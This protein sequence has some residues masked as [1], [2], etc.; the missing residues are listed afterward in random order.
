MLL[1]VACGRGNFQECGS[2]GDAAT[3]PQAG[4][5]V[6]LAFDSDG[7][8]VDHSGNH[9]DATCS[10]NCPLAIG[11]HVGDGAAA[12][13]GTSCLYVADAPDLRPSAFTFAAWALNGPPTPTLYSVMWRA[14]NG[15]TTDNDA[16]GIGLD[17]TRPAW[18]ITVAGVGPMGPIPVGW[19]HYAGVFDGATITAYLDGAVVGSPMASGALYGPDPITIGC[20]I[21]NGADSHWMSGSIDDVR[22]Y[23]RVLAADEVAAIAALP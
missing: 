23:D 8:L 10:G 12:F 3:G 17:Q 22:F 15:A 21:D 18:V 5:R 11:G 2:A 6:L 20:Q 7:L 16:F 4:L 13:D 1:L 14:Y 9:H 19:H